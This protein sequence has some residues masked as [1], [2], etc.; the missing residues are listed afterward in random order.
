MS[1]VKRPPVASGG[2]GFGMVAAS[3]I[4]FGIVP[5]FVKEASDRG[6]EVLPLTIF[7]LLVMVL[8]AAG[9][10]ALRRISFQ[11]TP[12]QL[13][14]LAVFGTAGFGLTNLLLS[15]SYLLVEMGTATICHFIYPVLVMVMMRLFFRERC[16]GLKRPA[17]ISALC[18]VVLLATI[19]GGG[20]FWGIVLA[21][22]S[23]LTYGVYV[24]AMDK[25]SFRSLDPLL[26]IFYGGGI[27][28]AFLLGY[29][30]LDA[31]DLLALSVPLGAWPAI[32]SSSLQAGRR[33][34]CRA[35][36]RRD[37]RPE[38]KPPA[39]LLDS[40]ADSGGHRRRDFVG[41]CRLLFPPK[42]S[43]RRRRGAVGRHHQRHADT[44][45]FRQR[46]GLWRRGKAGGAGGVYLEDVR[47]CE[48]GDRDVGEPSEGH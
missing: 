47:C 12:R 39:D 4:L 28:L 9:G 2:A 22:L 7:R 27:C 34:G 31:G 15:S 25:A 14:Q 26:V 48:A 11:V 8:L 21:V 29:Y 42:L 16:E 17:L 33:T 24:I 18:G 20:S 13:A 1:F 37:A 41:Y 23:G 6:A 46:G 30:A 40:T 45:R 19:S 38:G 32:L 5:V 44:G 43:G 3:S 36:P 10:T 35:A